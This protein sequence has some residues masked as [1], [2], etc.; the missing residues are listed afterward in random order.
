MFSSAIG[1]RAVRQ[2]EEPDFPEHRDSLMESS[3][4]PQKAPPP[5]G[6]REGMLLH[7]PKP[8]EK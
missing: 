6:S 1:E 8:L 5:Q 7:V 4:A 3:V 2:V